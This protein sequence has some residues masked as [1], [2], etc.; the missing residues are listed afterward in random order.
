[1]DPSVL[2]GWPLRHGLR[3]PAPGRLADD[4]LLSRRRLLRTAAVAV[5][6]MTLLD[7]SAFGSSQRGAA[8]TKT[9]QPVRTGYRRSRFGPHVGTTLKLRPQG[10]AAVRARLVG[11]EDVANVSGLAGAQDAYVLRFRGPALPRLPE[12]IVGVRHPRFGTLPLFVTPVPADG[13]H[14]D[15]VAAINRRIPRRERSGRASRTGPGTR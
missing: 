10:G 6:G 7:A 13:P 8:A 12:G 5:A 2:D 14:Q 3:H 11:V 1:M 4:G 15:Y 9:A